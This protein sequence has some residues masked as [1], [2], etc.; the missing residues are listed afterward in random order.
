MRHETSS[1]LIVS[2]GDREISSKKEKKSKI[3]NGD[4]S[5]KLSPCERGSSLESIFSFSRKMKPNDKNTIGWKK[6][7]RNLH[8]SYNRS[9]SVNSF[10]GAARRNK[11]NDTQTAKKRAGRRYST[12][13]NE[14]W[15]MV[16]TI[17]ENNGKSPQ[18]QWFPWKTRKC[19][20]T[21]N[22]NSKSNIAPCALRRSTK[23]SKKYINY[24]SNQTISTE[25]K[26]IETS[27]NMQNNHEDDWYCA[28]SKTFGEMESLTHTDQEQEK[29]LIL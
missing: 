5:N 12:G 24:N 20:D 2:F 16:D 1:E 8:P 3:G 4:F 28:S 14:E 19:E 25:L 27:H 6:S 15:K 17:L 22:E 26:E 11:L 7:I 21:T 9:C 18:F 29:R 13:E 23:L 10:L